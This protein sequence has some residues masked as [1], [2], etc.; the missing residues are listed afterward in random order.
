M[1]LTEKREH[2]I[3]L[4]VVFNCLLAAGYISLFHPEMIS[5]FRPSGLQSNAASFILG[6]GEGLTALAILVRR[7]RKTALVIFIALCVFQVG[8]TLRLFWDDSIS[9]PGWIVL[10]IAMFVLFIKVGWKAWRGE[11]STAMV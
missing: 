8:M 5:A 10:A 9:Q 2:Q 11:I 7:F 6:I 1:L 3:R 4:A